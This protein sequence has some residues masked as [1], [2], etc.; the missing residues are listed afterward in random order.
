MHSIIKNH[1]VNKLT[2]FSCVA[3][4]LLCTLFTG[5]AKGQNDTVSFIISMS[6]LR[7]VIKMSSPQRHE[8]TKVHKELTINKIH[9]V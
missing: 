6:P 5:L 8:G 2:V 3:V 4:I 9:F 7:K 1:S